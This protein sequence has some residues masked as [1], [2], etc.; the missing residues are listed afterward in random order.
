VAH[1]VDV[2]AARHD[3]GRHQHRAAAVLRLS[4]ALWRC[5][6]ERVA[7]DRRRLDPDCCSTFVT[8]SARVSCGEDDGAVDALLSD[9]WTRSCAFC[10][11]G[12]GRPAA[13]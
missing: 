6:C 11:P 2:D 12:P 8:R 1:V 9:E 10:W 13:R 7:V 3:V 5:D 4:S